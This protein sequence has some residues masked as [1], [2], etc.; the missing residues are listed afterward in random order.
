MYIISDKH[1]LIARK[2]ET[3]IS[4]GVTGLYGK[5]MYTGNDKMVLICVAGRREIIK[6]RKEIKQIDE[7]AFVILSDAREVLGKGFKKQ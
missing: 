1:E 6:L 3:E 5:G 7:G 2:I 4:R